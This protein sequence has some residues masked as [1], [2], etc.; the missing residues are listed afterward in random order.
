MLAFSG[1]MPLISGNAIANDRTEETPAI[2]ERVSSFA[3]DAFKYDM[4]PAVTIEYKAQLTVNEYHVNTEAPT[5]PVIALNETILHRQAIFWRSVEYEGITTHNY[6]L[7]D[8]EA[9]NIL[10]PEVKPF[11]LE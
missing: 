9:L 2:I 3:N 8:R 1:T 7:Y 6:T 4:L 10:L 5:L 11:Q